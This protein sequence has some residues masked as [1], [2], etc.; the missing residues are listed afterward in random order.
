MPLVTLL[1]V[2]TGSFVLVAALS[3]AAFSVAHATQGW[4]QVGWILLITIVVRELVVQTGKLY[5]A[6]AVH[7][8]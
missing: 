8:L 2:A 7:A 4:R 5:L 1:H 6:M 3:A